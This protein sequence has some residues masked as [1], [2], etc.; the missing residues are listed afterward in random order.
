MLAGAWPLGPKHRLSQPSTWLLTHQQLTE[1]VVG[2]QGW[3]LSW[4][5]RLLWLMYPFLVV[6]MHCHVGP[7]RLLLLLLLVCLLQGCP[8]VMHP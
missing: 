8:L 4:L 1:G 7:L 3:S 2:Q 6:L 5:L